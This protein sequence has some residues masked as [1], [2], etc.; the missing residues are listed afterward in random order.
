MTPTS[1]PQWVHRLRHTIATWLTAATDTTSTEDCVA[2]SST[3]VAFRWSVQPDVGTSAF[4]ERVCRLLTDVVNSPV[5]HDRINSQSFGRV[6]CSGAAMDARGIL[7]IMRRGHEADTVPDNRIDISVTLHQLDDK[8][9]GR[10]E[11]PSREIYLDFRFVRDCIAE[12]NVV[13]TMRVLLHEW[14]HSAGFRH[15]SENG[16]HEVAFV[17]DSIAARVALELAQSKGHHYGIGPKGLKLDP[18]QVTARWRCRVFIDDGE[19]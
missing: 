19:R 3:E 4:F 7:C 16:W 13:H 6:R 9:F 14:L 1:V 10:V 8:E 18:A 5:F 17:V 2:A 12:D 15:E 11:P